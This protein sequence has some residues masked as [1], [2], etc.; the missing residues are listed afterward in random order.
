LGSNPISRSIFS[1]QAVLV[2][3]ARSRRVRGGEQGHPSR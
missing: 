1:P 2:A 3:F